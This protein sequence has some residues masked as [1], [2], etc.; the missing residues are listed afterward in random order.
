MYCAT[1]IIG[2]FGK[3]RAAVG[4][5]FCVT[6]P[7]DVHADRL[8]GYMVSAHH[9][10]HGSGEIDVAVPDPLAGGSPHPAINPDRAVRAAPPG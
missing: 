4:T 10:I 6:V 1:R 5:G 3:S 2:D 7:S 8:Y 9:V